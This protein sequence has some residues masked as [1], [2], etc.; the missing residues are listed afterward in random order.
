[1]RFTHLQKNT[2]E[3]LL[4]EN[5]DCWFRKITHEIKSEFHLPACMTLTFPV[6]G[7]HLLSLFP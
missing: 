2:W 5:I 3:K 1:M 7:W 4:E 6:D